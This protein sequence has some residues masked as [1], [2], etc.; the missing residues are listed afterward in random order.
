MS[1]LYV[2]FYPSNTSGALYSN[3]KGFLKFPKFTKG[4]LDGF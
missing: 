4:L 1:D 2:G 3:S